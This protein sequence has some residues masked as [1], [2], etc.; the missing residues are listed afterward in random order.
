MLVANPNGMIEIV[1]IS[2]ATTIVLRT[3]TRVAI[4]PPSSEPGI[5]PAG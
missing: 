3:P 2:S 5:W 4:Q 1:N